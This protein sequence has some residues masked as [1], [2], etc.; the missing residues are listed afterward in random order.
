MNPKP[1]Q[2]PR[3]KARAAAKAAP[4]PAKRKTAPRG[5][6]DGPATDGL[7]SAAARERGLK[8]A[9][10]CFTKVGYGATSLAD[11]AK[12]A[13]VE[14]KALRRTFRTKL[15]LFAACVEVRRELD[16]SLSAENI[17]RALGG[18]R[19]LA[20][21][22][23]RLMRFHL[24]HVAADDKSWSRLYLEVAL[25]R[26]DA[27]SKEALA[28]LENAFAMRMNVQID[29]LKARGIVR[30]DVDADALQNL[31]GAMIDG[32]RLRLLLM[33][34]R[35]RRDDLPEALADILAFG[36]MAP[37]HRPSQPR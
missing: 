26:A 25:A 10:Q 33:P 4:A 36:V 7:L 12:R 34:A 30:A 22:L 9:T 29:G 37:A 14:L 1:K 27:D 19:T 28:L 18:A 23:A 31:W 6:T 8:A 15:H 2:K 24:D 11:V 16:A 32:V 3:S 35:Y 21:A 13:R 5:P 20:E 17:E